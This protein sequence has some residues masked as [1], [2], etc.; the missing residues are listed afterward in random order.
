MIG[1]NQDIET[2]KKIL[3]DIISQNKVV[4]EIIQESQKIGF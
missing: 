3:F 1:F 4:F 2:Q